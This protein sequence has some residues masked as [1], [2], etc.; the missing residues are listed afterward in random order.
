[1]ST[2]KQTEIL[3]NVHVCS[4]VDPDPSIIRQKY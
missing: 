1:M 2:G 3:Y 4:V